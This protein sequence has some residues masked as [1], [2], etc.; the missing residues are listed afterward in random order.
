MGFRVDIGGKVYEAQDW[1][2]QEAATPLAAGDSSGST[3]SIDLTFPF[4]D[5][6]I[7]PE[8]P[9]NI[10]GPEWFID[11]EVRLADSRKGFTLGKVESVRRG[12]Q[13]GTYTLSCATRLG[14]LNV[15]G[16]QAQ[17]F[18]GTLRNAFIYYLSLANISTDLF[19]D[20][21][22][23]GRPV[24]FPGWNGELWFHLK[25]MA[26]SQDCDIS[27]VSGVV[28]LRPI[29]ARVATRGRDIDRSRDVGGGTLA[30][31]VE[32]YRYDSQPITNELVYPPGGWKPETEVLNV[33]AGEESEYVLELSA[34]VSSVQQPVMQTFVSEHYNLSSVYTVVANDGLPVPVA[35]WNANGGSLT[36]TV[37]PDTASLR[38]K[39]KGPNGLPTVS[40]G[41]AT[42]FQIALASD[43]TGNRYSTLR[44]VGSGV[45]FDKQKITVRTTVPPGK[46]ATEVG[47]TIDNIFINTLDDAYRAGT[48]AAKRFS[49]YSPTLSGS[50]T[51]IN[52]RG[53]SG[54]ADYP[55]YGDVRNTLNEELAAPSYG[56]VQDYYNQQVGL[57]TYYDVDQYWFSFIRDSA[58]NQVFGNV[59][60][61]RIFDK[62]SRRWYRI[63]SGTLTPPNIQQFEADDD[64]VFADMEEFFIGKTYAQV[65]A[66]RVGLTYKQEQMAGLYE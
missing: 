37:E 49:G 31:A 11:Q 32:V 35:A 34:S 20:D 25:E 16:V 26:V 24:V 45:S 52:R 54:V 27:L 9:V 7:L 64:L 40:G 39:L 1:T 22:I 55:T 6:Q 62:K 5:P 21:V 29:R 3:G 10:F 57:V 65:Q 47:V 15:Y 61:C 58:V 51:A 12:D 14:E 23:G 66:P 13:Q 44:I 36:V 19:I 48:R 56:E 60:G 30:R 17:P 63:R 38:V 42:N 43:T 28:L 53:D 59:Q 33:N 46:T 8:H 50:V 41:P 4:L 18:V 2:V